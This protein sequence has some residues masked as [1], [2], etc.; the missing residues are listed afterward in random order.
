VKDLDRDGNVV[1]PPGNVGTGPDDYPLGQFRATMERVSDDPSSSDYNLYA[2]PGDPPLIATKYQNK[3]ISPAI[4]ENSLVLYDFASF[5]MATALLADIISVPTISPG[6]GGPGQ[7]K[8]NIIAGKTSVEEKPAKADVMHPEGGIYPRSFS[9][10]F[11]NSSCG[12]PNNSGSAG[13]IYQILLPTSY[14]P[15]IN[16][17]IKDIEWK[18]FVDVG[19][20]R[21]FTAYFP[22]KKLPPN[23]NVYW[24]IGDVNN[25]YH[26]KLD[27]KEPSGNT[28][29]YIAKSTSCGNDS[30]SQITVCQ[31]IK[32]LDQNEKLSTGKNFTLAVSLDASFQSGEKDNYQ[33][34]VEIYR[35]DRLLTLD[36]VKEGR[37]IITY[38]A[39]D[40]TYYSPAVQ[41][42]KQ[43]LNQVVPRK[44]DIPTSGTS[45]FNFLNENG[46]YED[47]T[48]KAVR[49]LDEYF[50]TKEVETIQHSIPSGYPPIDINPTLK[51]YIVA[52][53]LKSNLDIISLASGTLVD[54]D[55]LVG[56]EYVDLAI[57]SS[58]PA[59]GLDGLLELYDNIVK[60]FI[61]KMIE[62]ANEFA[63]GTEDNIS[64]LDYRWISRTGEKVSAGDGISFCYGCKQ[65]VEDFNTTVSRWRPPPPPPGDQTPGECTP[66]PLSVDPV[67]TCVPSDYEGNIDE[68]DGHLKAGSAHRWPGLKQAEQETNREEYYPFEYW[69]GIDCAGFT[70]RVIMNPKN[71][72]RPLP[73]L[74]WVSPTGCG[75]IASIGQVVAAL[76]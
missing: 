6:T 23:T 40:R 69:A 5:F 36:E 17:P 52:E 3:F 72:N 59:K 30:Y 2:I 16:G 70:Q 51:T 58:N 4:P 48:K 7:A 34:K 66:A 42:I 60:P 18:Y 39:D 29:P 46:T 8:E 63:T 20:C 62:K 73:G 1:T 75:V 22:G 25:T 44:R 47:D 71:S 54:R 74:V 43:K 57:N 53:Y 26:T 28:D 14:P 31:E 33:H 10:L 45:A 55:I 65:K 64:G 41:E 13:P 9:N 21:K 61:D 24:R 49:H 35:N 67:Y 32:K 68:A 11:K 19:E 27:N 15:G 38:Q 50:D 12:D 37:A 76:G 56:D